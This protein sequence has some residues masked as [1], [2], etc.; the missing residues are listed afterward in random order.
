MILYLGTEGVY[1]RTLSIK[2]RVLEI[3]EQK[4][5]ERKGEGGSH[6]NNTGHTLLIIM[7]L[8]IGVYN[9]TSQITTS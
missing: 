3:K 5:D 7:S 9:G 6:I 8:F 2:Y 1:C 4:N